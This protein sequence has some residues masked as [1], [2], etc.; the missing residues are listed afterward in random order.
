M[1]QFI[2]IESNRVFDG[3][4][5]YIHWFKDQQ[6]TGM[7]YSLPIAFFSNKKTA[8]VRTN[9]EI[10]NIIYKPNTDIDFKEQ[11]S[12][13]VEMTS[14]YTA[15][16]Q[17]FYV[18]Y[19]IGRAESPGEY[20]DSFFIDDNEYYVGMDCYAEDETL[21]INASN[22]GVEFPESIQKALYTYNVHNEERDNILLNR[23]FKELLTNYWDLVANRG[24][25]KSLV[26]SLKWFEWGDKV[27]LK[28]IWARDKNGKL[29]YSANELHDVLNPL[30]K[31][32]IERFTKTTYVSLYY[33]LQQVSEDSLDD[34]RNPMLYEAVSQWTIDDISLKMSMLGNFFETYFL[35]IH[36]NILHS[37]I[38][39]IVF[40]N[41][42]KIVTG[43]INE[44]NTTLYLTHN[45][46]C[47]I[48]NNKPIY[49]SNIE[50]GVDLD[51]PFSEDLYKIDKQHPE[52]VSQYP[53]AV[54]KPIKDCK[55]VDLKTFHSQHYAGPGTLVPIHCEFE[56]DKDFIK[57]IILYYK[58]PE[59]DG[60][61]YTNTRL[62]VPEEVDG[63]Y[64]YNFDFN[65][66]AKTLGK[67]TFK[68][69]F[70][71][72]GAS[73]AC[74]GE[75]NV[76]EEEIPT[77][78][79]YYLTNGSGDYYS[80]SLTK[81][82]GENFSY[83][84]PEDEEIYNRVVVVERG[85]GEQLTKIP[86]NSAYIAIGT[87]ST[88]NVNNGTMKGTQIETGEYL[89]V[90]KTGKFSARIQPIGLQ[91]L[92]VFYEAPFNDFELTIQ[93]NLF[94]YINKN[95]ENINSK[96]SSSFY[97]K[98]FSLIRKNS[99]VFFPERHGFKEIGGETFED[100]EPKSRCICVKPMLENGPLKYAH[101]AKWIFE[102]VTTGEKFEATPTRNPYISLE[103]KPLT[104]GFYDVTLVYEDNIIK[105]SS[106]FYIKY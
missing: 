66:I 7:Y 84:F 72:G 62:I 83:V 57:K 25:Y 4:K 11:I 63:K 10:Y 24:S 55:S 12:K 71:L 49:L 93:N 95:F 38:E 69:I 73:Y 59:S 2:D 77:L 14:E 5:P 106:V 18:F 39:S 64:I 86:K 13:E 88:L 41:N 75:F 46:K 104:P 58:T 90:I 21:K 105:Q 36:L 22:F 43:T 74:D 28:E 87:T 35:P 9:S 56:A 103:D 20:I 47:I 32:I 15:Y 61:R 99:L 96:I 79:F 33:A 91:S 65:L 45:A 44:Q 89:F 70:E 76:L 94:I 40:A 42:I 68:V 67:Y 23:K 29:L 34:E 31:D 19:I 8:L 6:S 16:G 82:N 27:R 50:A 85:P 101:V 78:K 3:S 80:M 81:T 26:N 102:N 97:A 92:P 54:L 37:T 98:Y 17:F 1:I 30:F 100:Y 51:T 48:N 60:I 53:A 52:V